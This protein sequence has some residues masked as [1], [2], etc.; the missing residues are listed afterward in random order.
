MATAYK[1]NQISWARSHVTWGSNDWTKVISSDKEKFNQNGPDGLQYY[2]HNV[3]KDKTVFL[4]KKSR[5]G[6][7]MILSGFSVFEKTKN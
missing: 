5:D 6:G 7:V 4:P 2:G 3:W 1:E